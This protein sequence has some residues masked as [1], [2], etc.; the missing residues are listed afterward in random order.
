M[1]E[2]DERPVWCAVDGKEPRFC[3]RTVITLV[4]SG[5]CACK[6]YLLNFEWWIYT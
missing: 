6:V 4:G 3:T 5:T 2:A 1:K